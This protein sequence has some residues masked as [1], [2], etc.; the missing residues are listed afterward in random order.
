MRIQPSSQQLLDLDF[1]GVHLSGFPIKLFTELF[2]EGLDMQARAD[3]VATLFE[4][5]VLCDAN[6]D[7]FEDFDFERDM[8]DFRDF[9]LL[10]RKLANLSG[11]LGK[12]LEDETQD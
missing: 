9:S 4:T 3:T 6:G 12:D 8:G 2:A 10:L 11:D 1:R 5:G 7:K